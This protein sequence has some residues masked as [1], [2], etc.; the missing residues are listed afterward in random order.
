M[1]A[2][3]F[4]LRAETT[5]SACHDAYV[6][7][8][9]DSDREV[10]TSLPRSRPVRRSSKRGDR[11]ATEAAG[12]ATS[13]PVAPRK[14]RAAKPAPAA[15]AK[16]AARK[17]AAARKTAAS[18]RRPQPREAPPRKVPA[19][20]Y[21]APEGRAGEPSASPGAE[22]ISTTIQAATEL[23]QIGLTVGR[24]TLQSMLDRLPKP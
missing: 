10:L 14:P 2:L 24:Q 13:R 17:P 22:L 1:R 23:A 8:R 15:P 16:P 12:R 11:P 3:C 19:A 18:A 4:T 20:G 9:K 5:Q 21:A 7:E 6:P